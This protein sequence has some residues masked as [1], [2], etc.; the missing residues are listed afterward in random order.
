MQRPKSRFKTTMRLDRYINR[1][2]RRTSNIAAD[3]RTTTGRCY[4]RKPPR[5]RSV[6]ASKRTRAQIAILRTRT[7]EGIMLCGD[8]RRARRASEPKA[9]RTRG[10][11]VFATDF[12]NVQEEQR[13]SCSLARPSARSGSGTVSKN[14]N[15]R[16]KCRCSC[17]LQ[18]TS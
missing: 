14:R 18:F 3:S 10:R 9:R 2:H 4:W 11:F 15:V 13:Q 1:N 12:R 7:R 5:A 16:S 17:V 6:S 8:L